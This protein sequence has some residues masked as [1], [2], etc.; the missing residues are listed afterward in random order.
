M[1][2]TPDQVHKLISQLNENWRQPQACWI[3]GTTQWE[4]S[5]EVFEV[6]SFSGGPL[7]LGGILAPMIMITC[8]KCSHAVL[9][10]ALKLG[11]VT[12]PSPAPLPAATP[13]AKGTS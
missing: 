1:K 11:I 4:V 12:Q 5:D 10:N 13:E 3:C 7:T 6:R 9:F 2:L 8:S